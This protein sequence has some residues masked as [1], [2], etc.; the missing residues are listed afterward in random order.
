MP[1]RFEQVFED[2]AEASAYDLRWEAKDRARKAL[3]GAPPVDAWMQAA[4]H[5][6]GVGGKTPEQWKWWAIKACWDR[7]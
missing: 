2:T 3:V 4:T 5:H 1:D 6:G 7:S